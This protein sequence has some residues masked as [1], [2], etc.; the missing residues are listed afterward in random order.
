M[1]K[2][3]DPRQLEL[4]TEETADRPD[5]PSGPKVDVVP[6]KRRGQPRLIALDAAER[7]RNRHKK[8]KPGSA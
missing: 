8:A 5:P 2:R 6:T 7:P 1:S 3:R 4:F